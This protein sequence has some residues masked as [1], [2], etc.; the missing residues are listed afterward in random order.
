[1]RAG[2]ASIISI[3]IIALIISP[4]RRKNFS[5]IISAL[6][7]AP[8]GMASVTA[9]VLNASIIVGVL[10][11][12][13]VGLRLSS[14][15]VDLSFGIPALALILTMI[16]AIMLG[17]GMPTSGAYIMSGTLLALA[18]IELGFSIIQSHLF[19]LYYAS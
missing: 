9:A 8:Y 18:L 16:V 7:E 15:I 17:M 2:F 19:V 14:L 10:F 13:G 6:E 4:N 5:A 1:M 12:T 11:M 3:L